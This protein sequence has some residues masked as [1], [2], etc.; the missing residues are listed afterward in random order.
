MIYR[1]TYKKYST[2]QRGAVDAVEEFTADTAQIDETG[3]LVLL[4][5]NPDPD[6]DSLDVPVRIFPGM[7]WF[8]C[9]AVPQGLP[10]TTTLSA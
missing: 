10:L 2:V 8:G 5:A 6:G 4:A 9:E 3:A 1:V 7:T